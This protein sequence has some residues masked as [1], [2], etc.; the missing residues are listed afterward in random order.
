MV[1]FNSYFDKLTEGT[2]S[3]N[4]HVHGEKMWEHDILM[5]IWWYMPLQ[6]HH[7]MAIFESENAD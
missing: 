7:F 5:D 2:L 4:L 6:H 3:Q 1:I